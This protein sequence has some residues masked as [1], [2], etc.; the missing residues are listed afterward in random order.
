MTQG[1]EGITRDTSNFQGKAEFETKGDEA[2]S[3]RGEEAREES[4]GRGCRGTDK[5][6]GEANEI[7]EPADVVQHWAISAYGKLL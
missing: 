5:V 6:V 7:A 1:H 2:G 4:A 3:D